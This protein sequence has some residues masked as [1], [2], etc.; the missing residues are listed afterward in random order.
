MCRHSQPKGGGDC[1]DGDAMTT[2]ATDTR[3]WI[4]EDPRLA[5][6][7]AQAAQVLDEAGLTAKDLLDEL[8]VAGED[9]MRRHY[10]DVRV[11]SLIREH[12]A[13]AGR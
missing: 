4:E 5:L 9:V 11:D 7:M 6:A 3:G 2:K 13:V 10:R 12:G 8:P 1:M